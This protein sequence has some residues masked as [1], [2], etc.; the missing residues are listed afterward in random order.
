MRKAI[1][2]LHAAIEYDFAAMASLQENDFTFLA[3]PG[4]IIYAGER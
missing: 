1:G 4:D 3:A 2:I